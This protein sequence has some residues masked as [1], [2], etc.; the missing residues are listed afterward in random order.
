MPRPSYTA[1][2][3]ILLGDGDAAATEMR[4]RVET[5]ESAIAEAL[6]H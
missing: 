6:G 5:F 1:L 3:K 2:D 4:K